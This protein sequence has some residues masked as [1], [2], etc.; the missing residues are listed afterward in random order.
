M[1]GVKQPCPMVA[2]CWSPAMP[3]NADRA[4]EQIGQRLAEL[5]R[6]SRA[7]PA[8][9]QP[10]RRKSEQVPRPIRRGRCRTAGCA[11]HWSRRSRATLPPVSRQSRNES[12]VPKASLPCSAA[13]R[14]PATLS[15]SQ[16]ILVAEKYGSSTSPVLSAT[17]AFMAGGAQ[18]RAGVRGAAVLPDD[19]V[20]D[21]LAGRAIPDDRG[22]ALVGDAD[23]RRRPS[24]RPSPLPSP[25][26]RSRRSRSR[27]PPDRARPI[28][29]PDRSAAAPA[30]RSQ[31]ERASASNT[32]AR[33]E[34]VPWSMAMR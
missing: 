15:S 12:T 20:V 4:A 10:A 14:A 25:R 29:A 6:R 18:R 5:R 11:P 31:R 1:P 8:A 27:F 33:V 22:L 2:A 28:R 34:V 21:R 7:P 17:V 26:A 9:A 3:Q 32:M 23:R 30:A 24:R 13:A 16:E 19:R